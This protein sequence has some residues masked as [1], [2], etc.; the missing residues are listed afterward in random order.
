MPKRDPARI[1]APV[2]ID[3]FTSDPDKSRAFYGELLGWTAE[4]PNPDFGGYF[5]F[6]KDGSLIAGGMRNDGTAGV[7]DAWNVYLAVENAEATVAA[8]TAAGGRRDRARHGG[9]RHGQHGGHHRR[10]RRS[11]RDVAARHPPGHRPFRRA[12]HAGLVRAPHPRLRRRRS[13]S[14]RTSLAGTPRP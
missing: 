2:W 1:G 13:S 9:G 4:E 12:W 10:R 8:A 7:P 6:S 14:I 3:L 11:H 5:N